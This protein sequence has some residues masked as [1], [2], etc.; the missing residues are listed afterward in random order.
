MK[1][2][3]SRTVAAP[4]NLSKIEISSSRLLVSTKTAGTMT[5]PPNLVSLS[6][7]SS[8]SALVES[9]LYIVNPS[10]MIP[11]IEGYEQPQLNGVYKNVSRLT[12]DE[13]KLYDLEKKAY[14]LLTMALPKEIFQ[15]FKSHKRSKA[16]WDALAKRC[17]GSD[18]LKRSKRTLL[19]KQLEVF[20]CLDNEP[21]RNW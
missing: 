9:F 1:T 12:K 4:E 2:C 20:K 6:E 7:Y 3:D 18:Q 10:L 19:K 17:E 5:K 15:F 21:L 16:L 14:V 13:K 8:W 11:L